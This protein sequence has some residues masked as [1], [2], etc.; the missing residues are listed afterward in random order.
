MKKWLI[1]AIVPLLA[2]CITSLFQPKDCQE[3]VKELTE[4]N[5]KRGLLPVDA[6]QVGNT[7]MVLV[8]GNP[9]EMKNVDIDV[10]VNDL[11]KETPP[12][13]YTKVGTCKLATDQKEYT[14]WHS[15]QPVIASPKA[16]EHI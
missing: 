9:Q 10:F 5:S 3:Y 13:S 1:L 4:A 6:Y 12:S 11:S 16:P 7:A 14:H 15:I 8:F 2:S